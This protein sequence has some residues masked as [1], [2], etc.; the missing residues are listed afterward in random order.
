MSEQTLPIF[1]K[2]SHLTA[3][4]LLFA[5]FISSCNLSGSEN[6]DQSE[7]I[8]GDANATI[9]VQ[10]YK[11]KNLTGADTMYNALPH[12]TIKDQCDNYYLKS[13][14]FLEAKNYSAAMLYA[15]SLLRL[16]QNNGLENKYAEFYGKAHFIKGDIF[17][18]SNDYNSAFQYYYEGKKNI[19]QTR[20][21]CMFVDYSSRLANVCY[22]Q[23]NYLDAAHYFKEAFY[24]VG[25]CSYDKFM[26]FNK[27]Q[28]NLDNVALCYAK[29]GMNDSAIYYYHYAL[30]YISQNEKLYPGQTKSIEIS[31]GIIYGNLATTYYKTGNLEDAETLFKK[32]I[33]INAQKGYENDDAQ[34]TQLKL[35][36][37]YLKTDRLK[38]AQQVLQQIK[39]ALDTTPSKL[40][41]R[42]NVE[43]R[44]DKLQSDYYLH[45]HNPEVANSYLNAYVTLKDSIDESNKKLV[46][47]DF[48]KEYEIL[49]NKYAFAVLKKN[50]HQTTLY[51]YIS[52][53]IGFMGIMIA[54][55]IWLNGKNLKKLNRKITTQNAEMESALNALEQSQEENTRMMKI[56]SHDLRSP[57]NGIISI[58]TLMLESEISEEQKEMAG[59]IKA[60]GTSAI[61]F[62]DDLLM[63]NSAL[64]EMNTEPVHMA[65]LVQHC[66]EI[67][68]LKAKEKQ[69]E[70]I[71]KTEDVILDINPQKIWRV[72]SNLVTNA[73]KFSSPGSII[74][75]F[76]EV[77]PG[78]LQ[79]EVKDR[80]I[81]IPD[82][83]KNQ[84]FKMFTG[85]MR[86]GTSGEQS[87]GLGL[88]ISMQI[89]KAHNG[90]LWFESVPGQGTS[91]FI[92]LP[93]DAAK[94]TR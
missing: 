60:S 44:L 23:A 8:D 85:A 46:S 86:Q 94:I 56:V 52:L 28:A 39:S 4:L 37:L 57:I 2:I 55:L 47:T 34:L 66:V 73:I 63:V 89:I 25:H 15:D 27:Q 20:D 61:E 64:K 17:M 82:N 58:A 81:G 33:S 5:I 51:L 50:D 53:I 7:Y 32:S 62:I 74:F 3:S 13:S 75:V 1:K 83:L 29:Y 41:F 91:F 45:K 72:I 65:Q 19:E 67:L 21:S 12:L 22:K 48:N 79:I 49:E 54:I 16:I 11:K 9:H 78:V 87:F 90:K 70:I 40:H 36:D 30:D 80:G 71:L 69:Q 42:Q 24:D 26:I 6:T 93:L 76:M 31:K 18:A 92:E 88:A 68:Q 35:A 38:D 84:M 10:P 59:M 14:Y 77:K 43:A